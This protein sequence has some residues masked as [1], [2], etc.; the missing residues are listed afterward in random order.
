ML[1]IQ[2]DIKVDAIE[3]FGQVT[4]DVTDL[5]IGILSVKVKSEL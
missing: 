1:F 3:R 4:E 2:K 5:V